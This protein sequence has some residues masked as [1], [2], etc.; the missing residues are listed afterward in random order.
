MVSAAFLFIVPYDSICPTTGTDPSSSSRASAFSLPLRLSRLCTP[1]RNIL[2]C[3]L[4]SFSVRAQSYI[5]SEVIL[6]ASTAAI[7]T[8]LSVGLCSVP[9]LASISLTQWRI[10]TVSAWKTVV[11]QFAPI[12]PIGL[13]LIIPVHAFS[14]VLKCLCTCAA[15]FGR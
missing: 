11:T 2:L 7:T 8:R 9:C 4:S 6:V 1:S 13:N 10:V 14:F 12:G 5:S 3:F 15:V